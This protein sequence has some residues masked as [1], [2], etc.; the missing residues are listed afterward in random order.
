MKNNNIRAFKDV[1][2]MIASYLEKPD[3]IMV[4]ISKKNEPLPKAPDIVEIE[5]MVEKLDTKIKPEGSFE[6]IFHGNKWNRKWFVR[7][8]K[9]NTHKISTN[10]L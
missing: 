8:D 6:N 1:A 9:D 10:E 4:K 5:P 3:E 7:R 2:R